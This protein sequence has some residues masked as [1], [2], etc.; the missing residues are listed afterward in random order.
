[1]TKQYFGYVRI[2]DDKQKQGVSPQVQRR[3]ITAFAKARDVDICEW[4]VEVQ[5]AAKVGRFVFTKM[6]ARLEKG[7][8]DGVIFHKIDRSAR[9]LE[10]WTNVGRLVDR[11]I[12]VQFAHESVD[13]RT[14][15]GRLSA[16]IMAVVAADYIRNLREEARK[17]FYGRL[18]QGVYPLPAPI[19]YLDQGKG[20]P[21]AVDPERAPLIR[22]AF[23]RYATGT[24]GL[25]DL[26]KEIRA[27][28]LRPKTGKPLTLGSLSTILNN[29]FYMG[30]IFI[31][32]T[33]E[34]FEGKHAPIITKALFDRVQAILKGKTFA[35]VFKNNFLYRRR[36]TCTVCS[37]HLIGERQKG[38]IYYRCHGETCRGTVMREEQMDDA[39]LKGLGLLVGDQR[40]VREIR[41]MV[42]AERAHAAVEIGKLH[43]AIQMR[44]AKC[45][46]R[47]L[48]LT[49]A[50]LD[51]LVDKEA[52]ESRKRALLLEKRNIQDELRALS[53]ASLPR[54]RALNYLE[55]GNTAYSGYG[56]ANTDERRRILDK[57]TS[58]L[59]ADRKNPAI[60]LRSPFQEMVAW[61]ISQ[62][63]APCSGTP[64]TRAMELLDIITAADPGSET[65]SVG[66]LGGID[67]GMANISQETSP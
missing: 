22:W 31:R 54:H 34:S 19:G 65:D 23:E 59:F 2:S 36:I 52:F 35:R 64:R 21:K 16:D 30:L 13:L 7:E 48:Q 18:Q 57:V 25:K 61:R 26:L 50:L 28:G 45:E 37:H 33:N 6:L 15:G 11:G 14:R 62:N 41:E 29:P 40:E 47:L 67:H 42:E 17:G 55:L 20:Q 56:L 49:D 4:F 9:N 3:D 46:D 27:R 66:D 58:N 44:L 10:D 63:G 51:R 38:H 32:R 39:I 60:A 8:A 24:V 43:D 5:T 1:M 53:N 12:D